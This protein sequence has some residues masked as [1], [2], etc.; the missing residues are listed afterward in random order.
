MCGVDVYCQQLDMSDPEVAEAALKIQAAMQGML[1]RQRMSLADADSVDRVATEDE[2]D[3]PDT[4]EDAPPGSHTSMRSGQSKTS[5]QP[6]Q[7]GSQHSKVS[8]HLD[9]GSHASVRSGQSKTSAQAEQQESHHSKASGRS[10]QQEQIE[11]EQDRQA[12]IQ[13]DTGVEEQEQ[14]QEEEQEEEEKEKEEE[15]EEKEEQEE[16]PQ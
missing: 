13:K 1:F 3:V 2:E 4:G 16:E 6:E 14:E 8:E 12:S 10:G 15:E 9:K 7:Q 5:A 11:E